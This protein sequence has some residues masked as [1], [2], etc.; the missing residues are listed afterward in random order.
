MRTKPHACLISAAIFLSSAIGVPGFSCPNHTSYSTGELK[1]IGELEM[2]AR[3]QE[4]SHEEDKAAESLITMARLTRYVE[5]KRA[6]EAFLKAIA[7]KEAKFGKDSAPVADALNLYA[8][9][10]GQ[11]YHYHG[12]P[13]QRAE[14]R[15]VYKRALA[16]K[17]S[18]FGVNA[19]ECATTLHHLSGLY[20][21]QQAQAMLERYFQLVG[22]I[23]DAD[24]TWAYDAADRLSKLYCEHGRYDD[25]IKLYEIR[26]HDRGGSLITNLS[27]LSNYFW[28]KQNLVACEQLLTRT[29][30]LA[31]NLD[32]LQDSNIKK[33]MI[34]QLAVILLREERA[35]EARII[36]GK[37]Q[38][39]SEKAAFDTYVKKLAHDYWN[40]D[41][42]FHS[43]K[44]TT[45]RREGPP[46]TPA[47]W[48]ELCQGEHFY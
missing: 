44:P 9:E 2:N 27:F 32:S 13:V 39:L 21:G 19:K 26:M 41:W 48:E 43:G 12:A 42:K 7:L 8:F 46:P 1:M 29:L 24:V 23:T 16:I 47:I 34:D 5:P 28:D 14:Q 3:T 45:A 4:E 36:L 40:P 31:T 17:E 35:D 33:V 20:G 22:E 15:E 11:A 6:K 18:V 37:Y 25:A 30:P 10:L 38:G